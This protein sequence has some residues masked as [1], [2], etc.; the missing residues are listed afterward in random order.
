MPSIAAS[1]AIRLFMFKRQKS[2]GGA[3]VASSRGEAQAWENSE[4]AG[5]ARRIVDSTLTLTRRREG[6]A[7]RQT[8]VAAVYVIRAE[9]KV[10]KFPVIGIV[11]FLMRHAIASGF[12]LTRGIPSRAVR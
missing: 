2:G 1:A 5:G 9:R 12:P 3:R 10:R 11:K 8:A 6:N 7:N 4:S